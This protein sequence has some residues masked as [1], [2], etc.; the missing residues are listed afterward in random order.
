MLLLPKY[1][2]VQF[3]AAPSDAI[4]TAFGHTW[5]ASTLTVE[6]LALQQKFPGLR[7]WPTCLSSAPLQTLRLRRHV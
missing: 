3:P 6:A 7:P 2:T 1:A 5:C 4:F